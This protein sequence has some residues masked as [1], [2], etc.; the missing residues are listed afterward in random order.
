MK[1]NIFILFIFPLL[2]SCSDNKSGLR[3]SADLRIKQEVIDL[4][5]SYVNGKFKAP[6]KTV[7]KDGIITISENQTSY[8]IDP[9]K[10]YMGRID[11]DDSDDAI[12]SI[13]YYHGQ[14]LVLT[15]HLF[16]LN[17]GSKLNFI[18]A[19]ESDMKILS[20]KD[21][22]I[23]AEIYTKSRNS[24]LANCSLCKEVVKYRFKSGELVKTE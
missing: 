20:I 4:A 16:L 8:I 2:F 11:D 18:R 22:V 10:I 24:P 13:D 23:T 17:T 6:A 5:T 7:D 12:I 1:K 19:I 3:N 15:E 21:R 9:A 14:Y